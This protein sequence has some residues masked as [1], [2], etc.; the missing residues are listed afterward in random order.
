MICLGGSPS[1]GRAL[2]AWRENYDC[3][4][5][6]QATNT[7]QRERQLAAAL[8]GLLLMAGSQLPWRAR[9]CSGQIQPQRKKERGAVLQIQDKK[10]RP[11]F[12]SS[13]VAQM[14]SLIRASEVS[15][16]LFCSSLQHAA[17]CGIILL[18]LSDESHH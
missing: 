13:S 7:S 15:A 5:N 3:A 11:Q 12:S 8:D 1:W 14:E 9:S 16:A 6:R 18:S 10:G 4:V 17:A 2:C